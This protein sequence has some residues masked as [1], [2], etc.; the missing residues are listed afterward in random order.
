QAAGQG[1]EV[2]ESSACDHAGVLDADPAQT[3]Q[4]EARLDCDHI[5]LRQGI[6]SRGAEPGAFVD[7]EPNSVAGAVVHLGHPVRPFVTGRLGAEAAV[8]QDMAHA[9]VGLL[10]VNPQRARFGTEDDGL[11]TYRV[12]SIDDSSVLCRT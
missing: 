9:E 1:C 3:R 7:F 12:L 5:A 10:A 4:V 11:L 2:L 6:V 8:D